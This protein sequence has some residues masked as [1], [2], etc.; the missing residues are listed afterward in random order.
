MRSQTDLEFVL[1]HRSATREAGL[2]GL[3]GAF[4]SNLLVEFVEEKYETLSHLFLNSVK[5]GSAVERAL[6]SRAL[7]L[8]SLTAGAGD[9]SQKLLSEAW[10]SLVKVAKTDTVPAARIAALDSMAIL[11]FVGGTDLEATESAMNSVWP[12]C[13]HKGNY[14][15][16]QTLGTNR[17]S[18]AVKAAAMSAWALL[19]STVPAT[20]VASHHVELSLPTLSMLLRDDDL[21][22]RT[23]TGEA[24]ALLYEATKHLL[25]DIPVADD[26]KSD[27]PELASTKPQTIHK[28]TVAGG[29]AMEAKEAQVVEQMKALSVQGG[30]KGQSKKE[31]YAQRASFRDI[32]TTIEDGVCREVAV[33]LP[34]G[35]VLRV[36]TWSQTIQLNALRRVLAEGFQRHMQENELLHEIFDFIPRNQKRQSLSTKEKRMY[37]SPNSVISKART[38][39]RN[40]SRSMVKAGNE[41]HFNVNLDDN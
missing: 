41:G 39:M 33:K 19:L 8:L 3:L 30:G 17:P 22:V 2:R 10:P 27:I 15:A 31:R 5:K 14:H 28:L 34:A 23:A 16:D 32:L 40:R 20:R 1:N 4:T 9:I 6:A 18:G 26:L 11:S 38:Q 13:T 24:L 35:D 12:V 29:K 7:G 25:L 37:M 36:N 21:A